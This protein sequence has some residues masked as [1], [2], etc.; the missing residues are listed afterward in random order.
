M[1]CCCCFLLLYYFYFTVFIFFS[2]LFFLLLILWIK[3]TFNKRNKLYTNKFI[4]LKAWSPADL[5]YNDGIPKHL[6]VLEH[7]LRFLGQ[8]LMKLKG[9]I[10]FSFSPFP[11]PSTCCCWF[12]SIQET[13]GIHSDLF[14]EFKSLEILNQ[15]VPLS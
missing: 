11:H 13:E 2:S 5:S 8:I 12:Y 1:N 3:I 6:V 7:A 4:T 15:S 10:L 9:A 14:P